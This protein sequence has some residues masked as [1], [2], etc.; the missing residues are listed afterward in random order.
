M[1]PISKLCKIKRGKDRY[2]LSKH[3]DLE[4]LPCLSRF[5]NSNVKHNPESLPLH[6]T[7]LVCVWLPWVLELQVTLRWC[8]SRKPW[9][10]VSISWNKLSRSFS[11]A[12][13]GCCVFFFLADLG[14]LLASIASDAKARC[15]YEPCCNKLP[16]RACRRSQSRN[17]AEDKLRFQIMWMRYL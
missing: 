10:S 7:S 9:E 15:P 11:C 8:T 12:Q 16:C 14:C 17:V 2:P 3:F 4:S 5:V 13:V 6:L 1:A